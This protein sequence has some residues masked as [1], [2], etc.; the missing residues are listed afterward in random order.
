[1]KTATAAQQVADLVCGMRIDPKTAAGITRFNGET[2]Y[3][4]SD[5]CLQK[6]AA[7]PTNFVARQA[8]ESKTVAP[9]L[10]T[11]EAVAS[12][13]R[14]DHSIAGGAGE[15][16]DLPVTGMTCAACARRIER[17][18]SK[19]A[20]VEWATV[21]FATGK[22]TVNYNPAQTGVGTLVAAVKD[23]GYDTAGTQTI[24]FVVDDSARP[25]G[26]GEQLEHS[27]LR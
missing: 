5:A 21:N 27:T 9:A 13:A 17:K 23:V 15:R 25:S 1:M 7:N 2:Y 19:T 6:F 20:G 26:G 11:N 8:A 22:A 4:C 12:G 24:E 14:H 3:F 18:L 10:V 16:V